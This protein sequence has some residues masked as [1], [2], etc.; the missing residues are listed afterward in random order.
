MP[1]YWKKA[2]GNM[3]MRTIFSFLKR[4]IMRHIV[5]V[6]PVVDKTST[7]LLDAGKNIQNTLKQEVIHEIV[8]SIPE[9]WKGF[10]SP[11]DLI[12]LEKYINYRVAHIFDICHMI[13]QERGMDDE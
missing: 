9:Q 4:E 11:K 12:M 3:I 6:Y 2:F 10:V 1:S 13:I 5:C 8:E 7:T